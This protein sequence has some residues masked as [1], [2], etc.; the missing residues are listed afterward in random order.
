MS[1]GGQGIGEIEKVKARTGLLLLDC[2]LVPVAL[3]AVAQGHPEVGLLLEGHALPSLLDVGEGRVGD[4]VGG[5]SAGGHGDAAAHHALAQ[6]TCRRGAQ[7][8]G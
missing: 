3:H 2:Q 7:H 6:Q 8:G 1:T 4:G 5:L